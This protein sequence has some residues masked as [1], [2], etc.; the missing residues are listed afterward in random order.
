MIRTLFALL[1]LISCSQIEDLFNGPQSEERELLTQPTT[2]EKQLS[3]ELT[4]AHTSQEVEVKNSQEVIAHCQKLNQ[5][6]SKYN[7]GESHCEK[8]QWNHVRDSYYGNPIVWTVFGNEQDHETTPR[9]TTLIMC[10]VHSDEITPVKFCFDVIEDLKKTHHKFKDNLVIVA[11]LVNPDGFFRKVPTRTNARGVD[12]NRNF[13]TNDWHAKA[14][15]EWK[16][17]YAAAQRRNPGTRPNSEQET[18]FQ[19]N[20]IK[21]YNPNK[22]ISV[23]APLTILDYDGPSINDKKEETKMNALHASRLLVSMSE[24]AKGYK[25]SNYPY[26]PGSLGN[27]AGNERSIPTYT[28]ELPTSD[29]TK[30]DLY[31]ERFSPA[32]HHAIEQDFRFE[33]KKKAAQV[34]N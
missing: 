23:H 8:T 13:P 22:V 29:H 32:I 6:F 18:I 26:F 21:R 34:N 14:I 20:L 28:L 5:Y 9:N 19:V 24:K 12:P 27:W 1:F 3:E 16:N 10:G 2:Q 15:K 25:I 11:P 30:T 31:W 4:P 7:W 17:R 33:Q